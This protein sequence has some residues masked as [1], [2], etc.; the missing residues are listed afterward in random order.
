MVVDR[1]VSCFILACGSVATLDSA[2]ILSA[3][4]DV[5]SLH[6]AGSFMDNGGVLVVSRTA[7]IMRCFTKHSIAVIIG[8]PPT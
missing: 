5:R 1:L 8:R 7:A 3:G 4:H 2:V 6:G